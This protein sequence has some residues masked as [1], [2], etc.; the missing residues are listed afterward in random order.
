MEIA[1]PQRLAVVL[2]EAERTVRDPSTP[3]EELARWGRIQQNAYRLLGARSE[4]Q[5]LVRELLAEELRFA[6][7]AHLRAAGS[8]SD[9]TRP[10]EELPDWTILT[11]RPPEELLG[12]YREAEERYGVGWEYLAAIHF[13]ETRMGR[14]RGNSPA[15]ARG[16]MQFIPSTWEAYGEGDID[17]DHDA[18][19]AAAR[20]LA[21]RGAPEDMA[22]ALYAYNP[23]DH[24]VTAVEAYASV[25]REDPRAYYGYYHWQ[26]YYR[27]G[28]EVIHLP[29]GWEGG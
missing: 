19:L 12:Y 5:P 27:L 16:P 24:Y 1:D 6:Y 11:P 23:S 4:W 29:E 15:G 2:V 18:I 13:V 3:P 14:I 20:Y 21:A 10:Q 25:M 9:L 28:D 22:R 8:L 17:D 7:D 26:V